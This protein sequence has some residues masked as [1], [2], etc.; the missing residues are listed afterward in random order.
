MPPKPKRPPSTSN[1]VCNLWFLLRIAAA[2]FRRARATWESALAAKRNN[3]SKRLA[4]A[5]SEARPKPC[6]QRMAF[7]RHC[8]TRCGTLSASN[9]ASISRFESSMPPSSMVNTRSGGHEGLS[10]CTLCSDGN[11]ND[12]ACVKESASHV[13]SVISACDGPDSSTNAQFNPCNDTSSSVW[14]IA[15]RTTWR[16]SERISSSSSKFTSR[17]HFARPTIAAEMTSREWT[18]RC[19]KIL[20]YTQKTS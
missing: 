13:A 2:S 4:N 7:P 20:R 1:N 17:P 15:S 10:E 16:N 6:G 14:P 8:N 19:R 12:S 18:P 11:A 5:E 9:V 3:V